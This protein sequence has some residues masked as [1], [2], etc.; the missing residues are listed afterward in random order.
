MM[1]LIPTGLSIENDKLVI[2]WND[3]SEQRISVHRLRD[4]CPCANCRE[5]RGNEKDPV[6]SSLPIITI[7]EAQPMRIVKMQPVGNYAYSI[8]FSDGHTTGIFTYDF[9]RS[10]KNH[11]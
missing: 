2:Q 11:G 3:S 4:C 7:D 8:Q 6:D 10:M 9:L 5:T 1:E